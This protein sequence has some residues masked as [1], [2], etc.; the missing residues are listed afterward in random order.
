MTPLPHFGGKPSISNKRLERMLSG[1]WDGTGTVRFKYYG[2]WDVLKRIHGD[3][4]DDLCYVGNSKL[5]GAPVFVY[6]YDNIEK[7]TLRDFKS[8]NLLLRT[9]KLK[10]Y[11]NKE[12]TQKE[13]SLLT[14]FK[15]FMIGYDN[16]ELKGLPISEL[17]EVS[18]NTV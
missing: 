6:Y 11:S 14:F 16:Y 4:K 10:H 9:I 5:D 2:E 8:L 7:N 3:C 1:G 18:Y 12:L 15:F 13:R 17:N